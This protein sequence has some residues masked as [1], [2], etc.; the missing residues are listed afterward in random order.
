MHAVTYNF[1]NVFL[2][3]GGLSTLIPHLDLLISLVGAFASSFLALMFPPMI[4]MLTFQCGPITKLKNILI[5][6]I[7]F[8]GFVTGT[9]SSMKEI[10]NKF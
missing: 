5:I 10:I 9:Y 3:S 8:V 1:V 7:G 4:E 2:V 6:T